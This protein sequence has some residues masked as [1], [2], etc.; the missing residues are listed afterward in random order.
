MLLICYL[1]SG[2][3]FDCSS[4]VSEGSYHRSFSTIPKEPDYSFHLW[5]HAPSGEISLVCVP[6]K[7]FSLDLRQQLLVRFAVIEVDPFNVSEYDKALCV[8]RC[9]QSFSRKVFVYYSFYPLQPVAL[10]YYRYSSSSTRND[11]R[12]IVN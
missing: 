3:A 6:F 11:H 8:N 9:G 5:C 2:R 4:Q 1:C 12:L 7:F 10:S